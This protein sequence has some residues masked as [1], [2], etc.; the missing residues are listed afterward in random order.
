MIGL[1]DFFESEWR[2][3]RETENPSQT[4]ATEPELSKEALELGKSFNFLTA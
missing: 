2:G 3:F 4:A 1:W